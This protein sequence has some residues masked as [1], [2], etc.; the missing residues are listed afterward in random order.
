MKSDDKMTIVF[1]PPPNY[2][3]IVRRFGPLRSAT[4]FAY[5]DT[6]YTK[7]PR[8]EIDLGLV[9]HEAVH[10]RQQ[11]RGGG[12]EAWWRRYMDDPAFRAE[13]EVEAYRAQLRFYALKIGS[14]KVMRQITLAI[15]KELSGP[16][17]GRLMSRREA[18]ARLSEGGPSEPIAPGRRQS[19]SLVS[20]ATRL[21]RGRTQRK[22]GSAAEA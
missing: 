1:G 9:R 18:Y 19:G 4:L 8:Q 3:E 6:I 10:S 16:M 22:R 17:Y 20:Q 11:E 2:E 12:P 7:M 5:G 14:R 21:L 15:S 13:Q